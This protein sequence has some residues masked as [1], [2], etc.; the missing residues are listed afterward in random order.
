M[1]FSL[2]FINKI[3]FV[4]FIHYVSIFSQLLQ[5]HQS[6]AI[7]Y[8]LLHAAFITFLKIK[9]Y[10]IHTAAFRI[11]YLSDFLP[12]VFRRLSV[13]FRQ[14]TSIFLVESDT[15]NARSVPNPGRARSNRYTAANV[16]TRISSGSW[17]VIR[18][19]VLSKWIR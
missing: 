2:K 10:I 12:G 17:K 5:F 6:D 18:I 11:Q 14:G 8:S 7:L 3:L 16:L 1:C 19:Q 9:P 15:K 4:P 13:S